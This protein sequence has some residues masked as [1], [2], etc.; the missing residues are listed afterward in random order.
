LLVSP[1]HHAI[2]I[3]SFK[4]DQLF[5]L[6]VPELVVWFEGVGA[7]KFPSELDFVQNYL[8]I[9]SHFVIVMNRPLRANPPPQNLVFFVLVWHH[10]MTLPSFKLDKLLILPIPFL[11]PFRHGL[12]KSSKIVWMICSKVTDADDWI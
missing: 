6:L 9:K 3:D 12:Q 2:A 8:S 7:V 11:T 1:L 5:I 10:A 4:V